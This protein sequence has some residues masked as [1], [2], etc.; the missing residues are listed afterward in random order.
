MST[1]TGI[2]YLLEQL[3]DARPV[4]RTHAAQQLQRLQPPPPHVLPAIEAAI[5]RERDTAVRAAHDTLTRSITTLRLNGRSTERLLFPPICVCCGAD[6]ATA[7]GKIVK[8]NATQKVRFIWQR[9][10]LINLTVPACETCKARL[11]RNTSGAAVAAAVAGVLVVGPLI[12][13]GRPYLSWFFLL[14]LMPWVWTYAGQVG[15]R[16]FK[17]FHYHPQGTTWPDLCRYDGETLGFTLP[18]FQEQ[19]RALN[20][21]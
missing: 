13:L 3:Q 20:P 15:G 4:V 12:W 14:L 6:D 17:R 18:V 8:G 10:E 16:L 11:D 5:E 9:A 1:L 7:E 21:G 2:D 19:F